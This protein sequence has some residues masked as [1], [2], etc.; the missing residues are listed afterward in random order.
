MLDL[1]EIRRRLK[2]MRVKP[3]CE[4]CD[5]HRNTIAQVRDN[6]DYRPSYDTVKKLSDYLEG[7]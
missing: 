2:V 6:L 5:L 3:I 7:K 1:D 4:A